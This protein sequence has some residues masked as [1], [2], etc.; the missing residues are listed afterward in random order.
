MKDFKSFYISF[1]LSLFYVGFATIA[2]L[3]F[4]PKDIFG[5]FLSGDWL[6]ISLLLTFPANFIS[7]G[8]RYGDAVNLYPVFI[9]QFIVFLLFWLVVNYI[10]KKIVK[11]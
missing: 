3:S 11:R 8:Y 7:F 2:I 10:V 9:I 4:Y 6:V 5:D 1:I